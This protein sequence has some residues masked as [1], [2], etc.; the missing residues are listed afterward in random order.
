MPVPLIGRTAERR[1]LDAAVDGL[2][3]GRGRALLVEGEPGIGKTALTRAA[4]D[5]AAGL[6]APVR[7]GSGDELG[8][9]LPLLPVLDAL[10]DD[11]D[12]RLDAVD[13]LLRGET[14]A[15]DPV[16]AASRQLLALVTDLCRTGPQVLVVDDLQWADRA[17]AALW[18]GLA[19]LAGTRP[20]LLVGIARQVPRRDELVALRR[21]VE[22]SGVLTVDRLSDR[23]VAT[24]VGQ[25]AGGRP[26][27]RLLALADGAAGNP[28]YLTELVDALRRSAALVSAAGRAELTGDPAPGSLG[29]AIAHRLD[30]LAEPVRAVLRAAALLGVEFDPA[31]AAAVLGTRAG[32]LVGALEEARAA[33][34]LRESGDRLAFRHPLIR[35]AIH[36]DVPAAVRAVLHRDAAVALAGSG[37]PI[38][39]VA[40]QF[41]RAVELSDTAHLDAWSTAWLADAAPALIAQA[42]ALAVRLLD[43]ALRDTGLLTAQ[44]EYCPSEQP[45]AEPVRAAHRGRPTAEHPGAAVDGG[46]ARAAIGYQASAERLPFPADAADPATAGSRPSEQPAAEPVRAAD[47]DRSVAELPGAAADGEGGTARAATGFQASA[48]RLPFPADAA[49]PATAGSRPGEL[50]AAIGRDGGQAQTEWVAAGDPLDRGPNDSTAAAAVRATPTHRAGAAQTA[51]SALAARLA[52][53]RYRTGDHAGAEQVAASA[54]AVTTD[55]ELVV[56]LHWTLAQSRAMTGRAAL[57]LTTL[58]AAAPGLPPRH[59]ARL[60]VLTARAHRDVGDVDRAGAVA[61]EALACAGDDRWTVGWALHVLTVVAVM[62]G[63]CATALP[64]FDRALAVTAADPA[65]LDLRLLLQINQAVALGDLDRYPEAVAAATAVRALA[66]ESGGLVRL[67]QAHSALGELLFDVGR[68]DDATAEVTALPDEVKD[69]AVACCDHGVAALIAFHRGDPDAAVGHLAAAKP[70]ARHLGN[71]VVGSLALARA[72][73]LERR[74]AARRALAALLTRLSGPEELEEMEDLLPETVRLALDLGDPG[75]AEYAAGLAEK[76]G[77]P[78]AHRRGA[79]LLC[80]GLINEDVTLVAAAVEHFATAGRP[81]ARARALHAAAVLFAKAG[82]AVSAR[83]AFTAADDVYDTLGATWDA[84]GLRAALRPHGIR[85]GPRARHRAERSGWGSLTPTEVRI[86]AL[87]AEGLSNPAIAARLVL[88][89]RTVATHVSHILAKLDMA[90]RTEIARE[91][92]TRFRESG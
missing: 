25:L 19:R 23:A 27:D 65:L 28:L 76:I 66:Q 46:T 1:R 51:A 61:A 9:A 67:A 56:D 15:A 12:P 85:R 41:L 32:D 22:R 16:A 81:L 4:A 86:A 83:T 64:L 34:V 14:G 79:A 43:R 10:R 72:L 90:S 42:P 69:P 45:V 77:P 36:D 8:K 89:P 38:R 3:A 60:L 18:C 50:A 58:A 78:V 37:A 84:A 44:T 5:R 39:R 73:D 49:D 87:V 82:D 2:L 48:E 31:D 7:W 52:D 54:L 20:L 88:S 29:A 68:W 53:A 6:G 62:R 59:R 92:A 40:R 47:L 75:A 55:P 11:R 91:A 70:L 17:T 30:F 57:T 21:S 33:G 71:R 63:D 13:R 80:R 74:G 26:G 24:L 35:S